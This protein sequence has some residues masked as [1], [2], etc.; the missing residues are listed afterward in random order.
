MEKKESKKVEIK[1]PDKLLKPLEKM[2]QE[3][4]QLKVDFS[5]VSVQRARIEASFR[6]I[7][8][9]LHTKNARVTKEVE[10]VFKKMNMKKKYA[11]YRLQYNGKDA[12]IGVPGH[13]PT[14]PDEVRK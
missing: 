13:P 11:G 9:I 4:R 10:R 14:P 2:Q 12:F 1:I 8:G 5:K 7:Y 3:V 6:H